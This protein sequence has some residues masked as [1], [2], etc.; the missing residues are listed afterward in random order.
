M[1]KMRRMVPSMPGAKPRRR[2]L[3][4]RF[5]DPRIRG[6]LSFQ[7]LY[8]GLSPF[9]APGVFSLLAGTEVTDGVWCVRLAPPLVASLRYTLKPKRSKWSQPAGARAWRAG[10]GLNPRL[11][12][13][14]RRLQPGALP[15]GARPRSVS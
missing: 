10:P 15:G 13:P 5:R 12:H 9:S 3:A 8:V 7:D 14:A 4:R 1:G 6:L 2:R 11:V